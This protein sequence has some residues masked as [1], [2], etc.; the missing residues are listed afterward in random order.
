MAKKFFVPFII[1]C[2]MFSAC[3]GSMVPV[4]S[5]VVADNFS[6]DLVSSLNLYVGSSEKLILDI[7]PAAGSDVDVASLEVKWVNSNSPCSEYI[8]LPQLYPVRQTFFRYDM[9]NYN[10][11]NN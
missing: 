5:T 6:V 1:A 4:D 8:I 7:T 10:S 2:M 3:S 11:Q 9:K